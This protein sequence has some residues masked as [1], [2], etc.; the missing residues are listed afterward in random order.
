MSCCPYAD[1]LA[2]PSLYEDIKASGTTTFAAPLPPPGSSKVLPGI[3]HAPSTSSLSN[4]TRGAI[5]LSWRNAYSTHRLS[6]LICPNQDL[7]AELGIVRRKREL[8]DE[9]QSA[10]AYQRAIAVG[11]PISFRTS[12]VLPRREMTFGPGEM[13]IAFTDRYFLLALGDKMSVDRS[14]KFDEWE[15]SH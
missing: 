6:P 4:S 11:V 13:M 7:I 8:E 2:I 12:V 5:D 15:L 14:I 10:S 1:F 3:D 9:P